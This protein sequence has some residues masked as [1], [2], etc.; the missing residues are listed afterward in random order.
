M[1]ITEIQTL[2]CHARMR[3]WVFVKV[4]TDRGGKALYFSRSPIPYVRNETGSPVMR[5]IGIYGY[6]HDTLLRLAD[7]E[8][9]PL[10]LQESLEQ[11]RALENGI[12]I[13]VLV[14]EH[15]WQGVDTIQDLEQVESLLEQAAANQG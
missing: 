10:E 3:N 5:H 15:A 11:L 9:S 8:P 6:R 12:E 13:R 1:K 7:L 4:V 14:V 2:V